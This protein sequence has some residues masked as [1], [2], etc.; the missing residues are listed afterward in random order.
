M[1]VSTDYIY[2]VSAFG[3]IL[4]Y[5]TADSIVGTKKLLFFIQMST[6]NSWHY[7]NYFRQRASGQLSHGKKTPTK[8]DGDAV[9]EELT[10][11]LWFL[12]REMCTGRSRRR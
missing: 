11:N 7:F 12:S 9:T 1:A 2:T 3:S 5:E 8:F 4:R 6:C 10:I